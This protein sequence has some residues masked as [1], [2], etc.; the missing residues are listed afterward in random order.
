M[1][2]SL[3]AI[4]LLTTGIAACSA[5]PTIVDGGTE[6]ASVPSG[7]IADLGG[8]ARGP[9]YTMNKGETLAL[10]GYDAVSY[11]T[12][13]APVKGSSDFRVR[14]RAL[15]ISSQIRQMRIDFRTIR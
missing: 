10:S 13:K 7:L 9:V 11:F 2:S 8:I 1:K 3:V 12:G 14:H 5:E 15:T 4:V 6:M